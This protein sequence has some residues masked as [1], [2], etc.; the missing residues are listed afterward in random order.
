MFDFCLK[1]GKR[2]KNFFKRAIFGLCLICAVLAA[3]C[4]VESAKTVSISFYHTSDIHEHSVPIARIAQFVEDQRKKSPNVIFLDTGDWCELGDLTGFNTRGEA[5]VAMMSACNYD[6]LIFGNRDYSHGA[7]R[8]AELIDRYSVPLVLA[9][10]EWPEDIKPKKVMPYRILKFDDMTVAIIGT[11]TPNMG[12]AKEPLFKV[13]PVRESIKKLVSELEGKADIIVLMTHLGTEE[14]WKLAREIPQID[15]I[16]GGH[17]HEKF[18]ELN[19][20]KQSQTVIQ[21]S[22]CFGECIGEVVIEWDGEK[23]VDRKSRLVKIVKEMPESD[24]VNAVRRKYV[25]DSSET[26]GIPPSL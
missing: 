14:D 20:D 10:C 21:H 11:A 16:F 26:A 1:H 4:S 6:A 12:H 9:N 24:K 22:G 18:A 2:E 13:H 5:I 23:I 3:T 25:K 7:D 19:F 8:L 17:Y 15:I